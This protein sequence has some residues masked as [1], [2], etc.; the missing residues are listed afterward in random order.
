MVIPEIQ[1]VLSP[2]NLLIMFLRRR[3]T[4]II[5]TMLT[6]LALNYIFGDMLSRG[7]ILVK[8]SEP[9]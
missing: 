2:T 5:L 7:E 4:L 6:G 8:K 1:K 9:C 3:H